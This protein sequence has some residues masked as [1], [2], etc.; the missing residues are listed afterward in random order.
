MQ[1]GKLNIVD[2]KKCQTEAGSGYKA[3]FETIQPHPDFQT[4]FH[5]FAVLYNLLELGDKDGTFWQGQHICVN[6]VIS[7]MHRL[8]SL[9]TTSIKFQALELDYGVLKAC[10]LAT[11]LC[12]FQTLFPLPR[13]AFPLRKMAKQLAGIITAFTSSSL[14]VENTAV[15][16]GLLWCAAVGALATSGSSEVTRFRIL[17]EQLQEIL[18]ITSEAAGFSI[19]RSF[20]W[21]ESI[22]GIS[23]DQILFLQ[24]S[25]P[26]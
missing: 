22:Y 1:Y 13:S 8:L 2:Q 25:K 7:V 6:A 5:H 19:L 9:Q 14:V 16:Q 17:V 12:I 21:P 20:V 4:V 10:W 18:S 15:T 11:L 3:M 24:H 26:Q 23:R